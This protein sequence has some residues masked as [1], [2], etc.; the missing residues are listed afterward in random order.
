MPLSFL[1]WHLLLVVKYFHTHSQSRRESPLRTQNT[2]EKVFIVAYGTKLTT[3]K[4]PS[5]PPRPNVQV[6]TPKSSITWAN[7][8]LTFAASPSVTSS[9]WK[10]SLPPRSAGEAVTVDATDS[11]RG[12]AL[13]F[14]NASFCYSSRR[15]ILKGFSCLREGLL[16]HRGLV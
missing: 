8:P 12:R 9:T 7:M 3:E 15:R 5:A 14:L 10:Q 13:V 1:H 4:E 16:V 2:D 6:R 11:Q